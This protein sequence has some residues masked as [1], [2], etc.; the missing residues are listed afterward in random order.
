MEEYE[1]FKLDWLK[2]YSSSL[3]LPSAISYS[4]TTLA[5]NI[6]AKMI[7]TATSTG[8]TAIHVSKFKPAIPIMAATN[9]YE[10]YCRLSLVWGVLPVML[11]EN[12]STDEMIESVTEKAK[13]LGF[14]NSGDKVV[15]VAGIP[16]GKPGTTNTVQVQEIK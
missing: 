16:W 10:T 2:E 6:D 3:D 9:S 1:T 5:K 12:L 8:S 13:K 11:E 14:V 4:A 15:I 7:I